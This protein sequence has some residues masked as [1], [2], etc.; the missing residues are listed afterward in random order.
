MPA[1]WLSQFPDLESVEPDNLEK[2]EAG[3]QVVSVPSGAMVFTAGAPCQNYLMV[4]DGSVRVQKIS[5]SGREIVLYRVE[6]GQ[7]CVLTTVCLMNNRDYDAEAVAEDDVQAVAVN[8][9][10]F[11]DLMGLSPQFRQFVMT[12]Y[13]T[14]ISDL[15]ALIDEIAFQR[16]D[17][18]LSQYLLDQ[19]E[20]QSPI[21]AT[22]QQ[23]ASELG[24][25]REVVSRQLKD[26]E[27][28]GLV[29]LGRGEIDLVDRSGLR[30]IA[31]Y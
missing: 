19:G 8:A 18:R 3:A 29:R 30:V 14:R 16:F 11:N 6:P 17:V 23:I 22:H 12:A 5:E 31:G 27:R 20:K 13:S 24:S 4:L 15:L 9:P 21:A 26:F 10:T 1:A 2:L 7:T 25:A 28:R